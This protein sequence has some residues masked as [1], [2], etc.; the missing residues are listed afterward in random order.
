MPTP[1]AVTA[2]ANADG[3]FVL[4]PT[5]LATVTTAPVEQRLFFEDIATEGKIGVDD[6]GPPRSSRPIRAG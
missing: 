5:Q 2:G 3:R 1:A 6:T 4:N